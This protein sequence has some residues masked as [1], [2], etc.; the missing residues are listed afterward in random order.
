MKKSNSSSLQNSLPESKKIS[1]KVAKDLVNNNPNAATLKKSNSS[2]LQNSL[3]ELKK[4]SS[5]EAKDLIKNGPKAATSAPKKRE[6]KALDKKVTKATKKN[7][8][9]DSDGEEI[10]KEKEPK[11]EVKAMLASVYEPEKHDPTGWYMSEK[12][13][14]VRCLWDG[15]TLYSRN[16]NKFYPPSYFKEALPKNFELD[17]ELW[18]KRDDFQKCVSIVK[19]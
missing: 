8:D 3:P 9:V 12:L 6:A 5:K 13:D 15:K 11:G 10:K 4:I 1:S 18:T 19:R 14:G 16:G 17:G 2:S 7:V